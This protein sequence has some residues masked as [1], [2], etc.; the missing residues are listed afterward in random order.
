ME[1]FSGGFED[2]EDFV[3]KKLSRRQVAS[4]YASIFDLLGK[5]GPILIGA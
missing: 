2:L 4:K 1:I 5:F 3:P